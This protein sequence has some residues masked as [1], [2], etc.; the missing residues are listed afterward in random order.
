MF[1]E[2]P[3]TTPS[4]V[5]IFLY[6]A[7]YFGCTASWH[8]CQ[9]GLYHEAWAVLSPLLVD[10]QKTHTCRSSRLYPPKFEHE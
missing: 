1:F 2:V 10:I 9:L 3:F 7:I 4:M 6:P 5:K 8:L